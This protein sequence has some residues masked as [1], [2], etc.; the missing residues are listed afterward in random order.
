MQVGASSIWSCSVRRASPG[1]SSS[2]NWPASIA[3]S[4]DPTA[5]DA[6]PSRVVT[7]SGSRAFSLNEVK[8]LVAD[9]DDGNS[10][11]ALARRTGVV[12]NVAGPYTSKAQNLIAACVNAGAAYLDL[13]G[14]IPLLRRV[15]DRFDE[16]A[17]QAACR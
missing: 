11:K 2:S 13:S 10:L 14:E 4:G 16:P 5:R 15:I 9:L 7:G 6:G 17:R 3:C 12:L 1:D 8:I